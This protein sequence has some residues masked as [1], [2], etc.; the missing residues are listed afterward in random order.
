MERKKRNKLNGS[1][2]IGNHVRHVLLFYIPARTGR[3]LIH[4]FV[5]GHEDLK[6]SISWGITP[7]HKV[8]QVLCDLVPLKM[9]CW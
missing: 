5:W 7:I 4:N 8:P 6:P 2:K 1:L 3:N 9:G